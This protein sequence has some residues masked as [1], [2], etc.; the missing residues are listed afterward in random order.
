MENG[1]PDFLPRLEEAITL[2]A[3]WLETIRIPQLKDM[4]GTYRA[5]FES[6]AATLVKK[7][8]LREDPYDYDDNVNAIIVPPDS[9]LSETGDSAELSRR[10]AAYRRQIDFLVDGYP[11]T[12]A[13]MDLAALKRISSLL[14]YVDWEGFGE[15]SYSPTTRGLARLVTKVRLSADRL[16]SR[17]LNESRMQLEKLTREIR[18]R[19]AELETWH[20]ESWKAEVR[21][22]VLPQVS[23]H[24][25]RTGE[26]RS[27]EM[28]AIRKAFEQALPEGT[29]HPQLVK[30]ILRE[31]H[32][33]GSA[34]R[35]E[36][37][38]I[39]LALPQP[40]T[41]LLDDVLQCKIE[42]MDAVRTLC[43]AAEEIDRKS[44]V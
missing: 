24:H 23:R 32:P 33:P 36:K 35:T 6:V 10:I 38:L 40:E 19:L 7:G 3:T 12:L 15:A 26:E 29:W 17:V 34:E 8:L 1:S 22:K 11:F 14:S 41:S 16:S 21:A 25:G 28:L 37:L 2:R 5:L 39:S 13:S 9:A 43:K 27:A 44:V 42:L 18:E 4:V 31:D 30:E 20:R